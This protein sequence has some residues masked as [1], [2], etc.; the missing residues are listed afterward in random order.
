MEIKL[1][2]TA[3]FCMGVKRAVDMVLDIAQHKGEEKM[4][5]YG[6]LI[7]NPQTV[8]LLKKRGIIPVT[9]LSDVEEGTIIIRAHG[10]SPQER[11]VLQDKGLKIID[12]TCPRVGRVQA[13]IKKHAARGYAVLIVG[14]REH[15]EVDGLLGY[16][17]GHGLVI[18]QLE[19]VEALP[20]LEHVCVVAQTTQSSE[21]YAAIISRVKEKFPDVVVFDTICDST[22][23]RQSEIRDLAS[24]M[25]AIFIVG[26]KNSANTRRL[27]QISTARGIPTFHVETAEELD[28]I[29]IDAY[30]KIGVS[31][32]ASTP[33]WIIE[34]V[35]DHIT[36][37]L[38]QKRRTLKQ[39][40]INIWLLMVRT[41]IY[42]AL[43]AG[44]LAIASAFLQR[45]SLNPI[46][47]LMA[48]AYVFS[49]HTLNRLIDRESTPVK[50]SFREES[51]LKHEKAFTVVSIFCMF[52]SLLSAYLIGLEPFL[53]LS[54]ISIVGA[55]YNT[56]IFPK[57]WRFRKLKDL[58]GTKNSFMAVAWAIVVAVVPQ[59]D[60]DLVVKPAMMVAF[61]FTFSVVFVRSALSDLM[62]IQSDRLMGRET[63][64]VV[65]GEERTRR[66]MEGLSLFLF[67]LLAVSFPLGW[68]S[69]VS[70]A[71]LACVFYMW[72]CFE[73]CD[74]KTAFSAA[75]LNGFL[76][77][78]YVL[79]GLVATVWFVF[80]ALFLLRT[81]P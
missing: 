21:E 64:P 47:V 30:E 42:S 52:I 54:L 46:A 7:H 6:P 32:G 18:G 45:E 48:S 12:A 56:R 70:F 33:N 3:G 81:V 66:L 26:G 77:T 5:T 51:Y 27:A 59:V 23:K 53:V 43:G 50:G 8:E 4:Y 31:A 1:A 75:V 79:A 69:T 67:L 17:S 61:L 36:G 14:D 57:S 16:S 40:L 19:D 29:P 60:V 11:K 15:P 76:E 22:E 44:C 63:I 10:I 38:S 68:T 35:V 80:R 28:R 74:R 34:R 71:L 78:N 24:E 65:I 37:R 72:I 9:D 58:P 13:I 41:D 49:V 62:D 20:A 2:R 73:L 55:L 25:D 39:R